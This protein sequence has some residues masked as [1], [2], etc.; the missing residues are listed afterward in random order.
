MCGIAGI[1]GVE[2]TRAQRAAEAMLRELR[3]RGPDDEGWS[4]I[5]D[6]RGESPPVCLVHTRLSILDPTPAGH[7]PM[8]DVRGSA[9][10]TYNGEIYNFREIRRELEQRERRFRTRCDTEVLIQAYQEWGTS[11]VSRLRGMFAFAIADTEQRSVWLCRDRL[12]IKP[13]YLGEVSGGGLVFASE[14]RALLASGLLQPR[15]D[16]VALESFLAQG[17]VFGCRSVVSGVELLDAGE[18]RVFDWGARERQRTQYWQV[19]WSR[20]TAPDGDPVPRLRELLTEAVQLRLI[21]DVPLGLFLSSGVDSAVLATLATAARHGSVQTV[22]VGF[23]QPEFDETPG[24]VEVARRLGT[25]HR[26]VM[27]SGSDV[28]ADFDAAV[29]AVDQPSVDGFNTYFVSRAAREV[30][31]KAALSGLGG[32]E[33]FCGY[34]SFRDVERAQRAL[35]FGGIASGLSGAVRAVAT[36]ARSRAGIKLAELMSRTL[37]DLSVYLLRRELFLPPERRLLQPTPTGTD[38]QSG[39]EK[40]LLDDVA[41][42]VVGL[43]YTNRISCFELELY[44]RQMLLRDSDVFSMAHGLEVRVPLLDHRVVECVAALPGSWKRQGPWPKQLLIEAAGPRLPDLTYKRKK[45]GFTFPWNAWVRGPLR[46]KA[47]RAMKSDV[48]QAAG[49]NPRAP[50]ELLRRFEAGDP[51]AS[52]LQVIA[53]MV[54]GQYLERWQLR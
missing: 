10:I 4:F 15:L 37:D 54:L 43:D 53:L 39:V 16:R 41:R 48:W 5:E 20:G 17:A 51:A 6:P 14:L 28:L 44:M 52:P 21:A 24:A 13:L 35:R 18:F 29:A 26:S 19:P 31:L 22:S 27:L 46:D 47:W 2:R 36:K 7:Q 50:A 3:H 49:L 32:D 45:R 8:S 23:D 1:I 12:G 9:H 42:R 33:L 30:G 34:A 38:L 40:Q 25:E 11:S